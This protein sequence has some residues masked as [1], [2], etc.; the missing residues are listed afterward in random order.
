[1][2]SFAG[3]PS[4]RPTPVAAFIGGSGAAERV[5]AAAADYAVGVCVADAGDFAGLDAVWIC[6]FL[7]RVPVVAMGSRA[8]YGV[9]LCW[10]GLK[11][12][13]SW[14]CLPLLRYVSFFSAF[15]YQGHS[16]VE[17]SVKNIKKDTAT[18][19]KMGTIVL[20]C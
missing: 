15:P 9:L 16:S 6:D 20:S 7:H 4:L 3:D 11:P 10:F 5:A 14:A 17:A 1:M 13:G 18:G 2:S 12:Y 19:G 8:G